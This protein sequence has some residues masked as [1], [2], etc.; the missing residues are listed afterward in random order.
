MVQ[1]LYEELKKQPYHLTTEN[2][3]AAYLI[4]HK[5]KVRGKNVVNQLADLISLIRFQLKQTQEIR[6]F[7]EDV[8]LRFRDWMLAKNAGPKQFTEEQTEWLRM[9]RDH[10]S[11][12][13]SITPDD[14]EYTPFNSNGGLGKFYQI[15]GNEYKSI[16]NEIN[17]ALVEAA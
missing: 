10:I 16:L 3:W 15:F 6:P 8:N 1:E 4:Q 2:L 14:L 11:I 12:S 5:D 7:S 13:I 17:T 9:I